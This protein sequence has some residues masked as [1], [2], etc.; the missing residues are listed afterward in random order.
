[1]RRQR[2]HIEDSDV[3]LEADA[4]ARCDAFAGDLPDIRAN[5]WSSDNCRRHQL[6]EC[7]HGRLKAS[8]PEFRV[9][10]SLLWVKHLDREVSLVKPRKLPFAWESHQRDVDIPAHSAPFT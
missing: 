9:D 3:V 1:M 5:A 7:V 10:H 2:G 4:D 6:E 8:R